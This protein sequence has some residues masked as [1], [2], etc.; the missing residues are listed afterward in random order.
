MHLGLSSLLEFY[1]E[2]RDDDSLV[3]GTVIATRGSTYRKV[4]AMMLISVDG[5]HCGLISGGCLEADL[6]QHARQVFVDGKTRKV[7]YDLSADA[8]LIWGLGIGCDGVIEL[9]L[10]RLEGDQGFGFLE[11]LESARSARCSGVLAL[12][13]SSSDPSHSIGEFA[14]DCGK[15][16]VAGDRRLLQ[17]TPGLA[18]AHDMTRRFWLENVHTKDG[19][20]NTLFIPVTPPLAL[21]ICGAGIDAVPMARLATE[22]GWD[23]TLVDHR[24]GFAS[25]DR[26]PSACEVR[27]L[28]ADALAAKIDLQCIDA[29]VIMSHNLGHDQRYLAQVVAA[30]IPYIGLLGPRARRDRLLSKI[31]AANGVDGLHVHGPA[32]LDIGAEMPESVALSIVAE[33]HACLNQRQGS[34]LTPVGI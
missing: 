29:V 34:E 30:K 16:F 33:I 31:N 6:A 1:R 27:L 7:T 9:M 14:L 23:C 32:G 11:A 17:Y 15:R 4:G 8:D 18:D 10:Q 19:D 3:L 26:F 21:L 5:S 2:H 12:L 25:A 13:I 20:L 24:S 28:Q 22:M